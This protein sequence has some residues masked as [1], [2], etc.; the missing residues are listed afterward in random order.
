MKIIKVNNNINQVLKEAVLL[1]KKGG[2]IVYPTETSYGLGCDATNRRAV[3]KIFKI[4]KRDRQK[5]LTL[6][7]SSFKMVKDYV[8]FDKISWQLAKKYWPGPLTLILSKK[9]KKLAPTKEGKKVYT[10]LDSQNTNFGIRI[11]SQPVALNLVKILNRPLISTSA[12]ISGDEPAYSVTEILKQFKKKK[13]Q[14]DLIL[15]YGKLK[16]VKTSTVVKVENNKIKILRKGPISIK[17]HD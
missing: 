10:D 6:I 14:P 5:S 13:N 17:I 8:D 15:D 3:K 11:S 1:L 9:T 4:K 12:N 16:K 2:V 7:G